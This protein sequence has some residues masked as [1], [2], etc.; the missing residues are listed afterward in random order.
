MYQEYFGLNAYPFSLTPN[1]KFYANLPVHHQCLQMAL[2]ALKLGEGLVKI[3]GEV[4]TGKTLLCRQ[5]LASL[6]QDRFYTAFIPNPYLS[7]SELRLSLAQELGLEVNRHQPEKM[8]LE[9]LY[10][11]LQELA[12][13]NL[14]V[15]LVVDEAQAMQVETLEALRLLTNLETEESKLMQIMLFGQPELDVRLNQYNMRQLKQRITFSG[16]LRPLNFEETQ[17][18]VHF[19]LSQAGYNGDLVFSPEAVRVI[20]RNT[21]GIPRLINII[22]HKSLMLAYGANTRTVTRKLVIRAVVDTDVSRSG[23]LTWLKRRMS[24]S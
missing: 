7:P 11:R 24:S 4:G 19:R 16:Y 10:M 13:Q 21:G 2:A 9:T 22:C 14:S 5:L 6:P 1:T 18:Y 3:T 20:Y 8:L 12:M 15:V 23:A 17:Q